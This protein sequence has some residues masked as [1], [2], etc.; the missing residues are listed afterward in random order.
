MTN[1][2]RSVN[3]DIARFIAALVIMT[4]HLNITGIQNYPFGGGWIYVEFFCIIT[5]YYTAKHF[6][7]K[8]YIN[9]IKES[10]IYTLK[11]FIPFLPY[12]I[13]ITLLMYVTTLTS[14][15]ISGE[16]NIKGF[17]FGFFDNFIFDIMF[18]TRSFGEFPL[19]GTLWYLSAM[20]IGFPILSWFVQLRNRYWIMLIS[21]LYPLYYYGHYGFVRDHDILRVLAAMCLGVF[22]YEVIYSFYSYISSMNKTFL[23]CVETFT[24]LFPLLTTYFNIGSSRF[25]IFCFV[26]CLG[27]MLSNISYTGS[28]RS[29][30]F[31]YCGKLSMPL[32]IIHWYIGNL[33]YI[34]DEKIHWNTITKIALYYG[35][36]IISSMLFM[37]LVDHWRWFQNA[38]KK[39]IELND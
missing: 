7:N 14:Q 23:T 6:E 22:I 8:N 37:Y 39:P 13:T 29:K 36:S 19:V 34:L 27:I 32:F 21:I 38:L 24:F 20:F 30:I 31:T 17:F 11:K 15:L 18:L 28:I 2:N 16:I 25:I 4:H 10:I 12:T 35:I 9:T 26:L 33:L 1:N 3:V 5:G